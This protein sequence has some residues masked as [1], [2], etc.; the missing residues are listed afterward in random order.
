MTSPVFELSLTAKAEQIDELGHVNNAE[1]VRW[2]QE[3]ATSHWYA[4]A[5]EALAEAV[6]WVVIRHEIDYLRPLHEGESVIAR[7]WIDE[8]VRGARS[9][10]HMEFVGEDGKT[11]VRAVTNWAM[12]DK[13]SGRPARVRKEHIAPFL[14]KD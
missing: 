7:T 3:V 10:R 12:I 9:N 11:L 13:A 5:D 4:V 14:A 2:I 8:E 1:W 6:F